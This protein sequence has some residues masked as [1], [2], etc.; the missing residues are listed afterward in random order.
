MFVIVFVSRKIIIIYLG[1]EI[2]GLNSLYANLLDFLNLAD[3]GVGV[4]VQYQLYDSLVKRDEEVLSKILS[5]TR[6]LYNIIGATV[7]V[8]GVILSFFVPYLIKNSPYPLYYVRISF[9]ISV[10]GVA[11]GYFF[12]HM[13]LFLQADEQ[14]GLVNVLDIITKIIVSAISI[15]AT[16]FYR[17]YFVYLIINALYGIVSNYLIC[18][19]FKKK[20]PSLSEKR[21]DNQKEIKELVSNLKNVIP[22][23][24][25]NYVYNSTDNV[26]I[27]KALG[28]VSVALYSNYM[29]IINGIMEIEYL[30]GNVI[31]SSMGKIVKENKDKKDI[32]NFYLIFQYIQFVFTNFSTIAITVLCTPFIE[33]WLGKRY[34][35]DWFILGLIVIDFFVHSMY[36]PSYVMYGSTGKFKE[37]RNITVAS[38]LI[39]LIV[40]IVLVRIIGLSGVIVGT[41]LTDIYIW[42]VRS[43]Q[44]VCGYFNQNGKTYFLKMIKYTIITV[45][46]LFVTI[47]CCYFINVNS[48]FF[49]LIVKGVI[50]IVVPNTIC[51]VCTIRSNE[52]NDMVQFFEK[53]YGGKT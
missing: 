37:D 53:Q 42:I 1:E 36:Q 2:L 45:L 31:S 47:F 11:L 34:V 21:N 51:V 20:Y 7:F 48:L 13:R 16:V 25:S 32:Y 18:Y 6:K 22:M 26:I 17:N 46:S 3:L 24:L 50:C 19:V 4:A 9:L 44:V 43:N 15:I 35:A 23:K 8:G 49:E 30:F 40:S 10:V 5:A 38:A 52:F 12:V 41:F 14:L 33:I 39:N 29:I 27:T 28:L